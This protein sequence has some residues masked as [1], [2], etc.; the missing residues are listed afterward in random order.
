MTDFPFSCDLL[1]DSALIAI[2]RNGKRI[3]SRCFCCLLRI[4]FPANRCSQFVMLC[5]GITLKFRRMPVGFKGCHHLLHRYRRIIGCD[6]HIPLQATGNCCIGK[7]RGTN[8]GRMVFRI[9]IEKIGLGMQACTL[10][11]IGHAYLH[12]WQF[13]QCINGFHIGCTHIGCRNQSQ[14]SAPPGKGLQFLINQAQAAPFDKGY[15]HI[16]MIRGKD[17]LF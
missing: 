5:N 9:S 11:I 2:R 12:A 16:D 7:V 1:Q 15:Q 17:F 3:G 4:A 8:I 6:F 14:S 10:C 13:G